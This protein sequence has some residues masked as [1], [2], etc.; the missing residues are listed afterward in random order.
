MRRKEDQMFTI[1]VEAGF[2][3]VHSVR[4]ADG[5]VEDP[6]GHDW[7]VRAHFACVELD[8]T[9]MVVDFSRAQAALRSVVEPLDEC[10]LNS[11]AALEGL[12]PTAEVVA[13]F[14]LEG[15]LATGLGSVSRVEVT[16]APGCVACYEAPPHSL[17]AAT[18]DSPPV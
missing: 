8:D 2:H 6:H 15:L 1:V 4:F 3:A 5:T 12:N 18:G 9:G 13:R 7:E 10:D 17:G 16:E 11:S 14:V